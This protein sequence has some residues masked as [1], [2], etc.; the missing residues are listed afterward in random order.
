M[1]NFFFDFFPI[2]LLIFIGEMPPAGL[3]VI[4]LSK[5]KMSPLLIIFFATID[6]LTNFKFFSSFLVGF[7]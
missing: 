6:F 3:F 5:L 4:T 7:F 1:L 2:I